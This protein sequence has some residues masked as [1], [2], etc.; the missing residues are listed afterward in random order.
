MLATLHNR[1]FRRLLLGVVL[2][3]ELPLFALILLTPLVHSQRVP[4]DFVYYLQASQ[5]LAQGDDPYRGWLSDSAVDRSR[6]AGYIYPPLLAWTLQPAVHLLGLPAVARHPTLSQV[7][8]HYDAIIVGEWRHSKALVVGLVLCQLG[9]LGVFAIA[10]LR[11]LHNRTPDMVLLLAALTIGFF[12]VQQNFAWGQVN[13]LLLALGS[14]WYFGWSRGDSLRSGAAL[15]L[16]TA[17][18]LIQAPALLLLIASRRWLTLAGALAVIGISSL[19]ATPQYLR[20]YYTQVLPRL[21]SGTGFA[22]NVAPLGTIA[23]LVD[24]RSA[25]IG[26]TVIGPGVRLAALGLGLAVVGV[27]AGAILHA[28]RRGPARS[29]L[30]VAVVLSAIPL[31]ATID[32]PAHLALELLPIVI[33]LDWALQA[34]RTA[35]AVAVLASWVLMGPVQAALWTDGR[36]QIGIEPFQE[37]VPAALWL[38]WLSAVWASQLAVTPRQADRSRFLSSSSGASLRDAGRVA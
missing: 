33:L 25:H 17:I 29:A 37:V 21:G 10:T 2:L 9:S 38:L 4:D 11:S 35:L 26:Q 6:V 12:P 13:L 18:K 16:G 19:I 22:W 5:L 1:R 34:E 23:R 7:H 28:R 15:G 3:T 14:L 8:A 31:V 32:W 24:G 36:E 27:S 20:E 30:E